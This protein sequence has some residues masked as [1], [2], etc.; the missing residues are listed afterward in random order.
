MWHKHMWQSKEKQW[1]GHGL[2]DMVIIGLFTIM[3]DNNLD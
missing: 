2:Y 1:N 3:M